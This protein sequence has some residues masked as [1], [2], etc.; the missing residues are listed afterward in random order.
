[1]RRHVV[2]VM[3]TGG[4]RGQDGGTRDGH[5]TFDR[6]AVKRHMK[7]QGVRSGGA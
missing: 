4:N 7:S 2:F 1:M 3:G 6:N 5:I